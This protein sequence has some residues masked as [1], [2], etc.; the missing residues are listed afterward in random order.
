MMNDTKQYQTR[1][2]VRGLFLKRLL[3]G[4]VFALS[5][6]LSFLFW[7]DARH[8]AVHDLHD[9]FQLHA[10]EAVEQLQQRM[11]SYQQV[12]RGVRALFSSSVSVDRGEFHNY[13]TALD[14]EQHY[15]GLQA[16]GHATIIQSD[17]LSQH[18]DDMRKQGFS[19]YSISPPGNRAI[20]APVV[21]IEPMNVHNARVIGYD[22]NV[23]PIRHEAMIL[24][25]DSGT[26]AL[27]GKV[28]LLQDSEDR[29]QAGFL[30][31]MPL[32][33]NGYPHVTVAER[34]DNITGWVIAVFRMSDLIAGLDST[35]IS[36]LKLQIYDGDEISE[37]SWMYNSGGTPDDPGES[38]SDLEVI[39]KIRVAGHTWTLVLQS[40]PEFESRI[41]TDK[42]LLIAIAGVVISLLLALLVRDV[43][44]ARTMARRLRDSEERWRFAL[45]GAGDGVWDWNVVTNEVK[46][47]RRWKEMLGFSDNE[48]DNEFS[49]WDQRVH[50]QDRQSAMNDIRAHI[51]GITPA[52]VN[53]HR[54]LCKDGSWKWILGRGKII[55]RTPEGK[56]LRII[57][58]QTDITQRKLNENEL[59]QQRDFN[60]AVLDVAGNVIAVLDMSGCFVLINHAVEELTGFSKEELLGQ[61]I[62]DW[63]IPEDQ[64]A[65]VKQVV[66][67]LKAGNVEIATRYENDWLTR[68]G[69]RRTFSWH[70]T[71]LK[72][73]KGKT[74]HIVT[75]GYD[76]TSRKSDE[77]KIRRLSRL[78]ATL[79]HC[80]Q[81]IVH[82]ASRDDLFPEA[83]RDIVV[84]G[85]YMMA[86][87]G[88]IDAGNRKVNPVASYGEGIDYLDN[89][90]ITIDASE[91]SGRGPT[92]TSIRENQA[93]W[94]QDF[95]N[96][97]CTRYWHERGRRFNWGSS[98]AL[99]LNVSGV[100]VGALTLYAAEVDAFDELAREL[101]LQM[102]ADIS[103][104]LDK[105]AH[106]KQRRQAETELNELNI[107]LENRVRE[108]T[109]ALRKAVEQ[110]DSANRAKS[111]FLSNMSHEIR[112]PL[113]AIIGFS[114]SLMTDDLDPAARENAISTVVRNGKHLQQIIN[115]VLDL[116]K[117]EAGQLDINL[118]DTSV[119]QVLGE[120]DTLTGMSA[121]EKGLEF[122]I[123][124]HFPLPRH[125]LTDPTCL[126]QIL[127]N[128]CSNAIKFTEKGEVEV[129][130]SCDRTYRNIR[131]VITDT[132]IGMTPDEVDRIF[133]PFAQADTTTTRRFGGTGLGLS[134]S[135][136]LANELG[137]QLFCV[138][139]KDHGSSFTLSITNHAAEAAVPI[140]SIEEVF[141]HYDGPDE[142]VEVRQLQ[143]RILLVEDSVDN[144]QLISMYVH[145][146]GASL[147]ITQNGR[148]GVDAALANN[149]DLILMDMQM[150]VMD[151][152]AAT[153][154]LRKNG[155]TLPIVSLTANAMLSDRE[156]CINAG[157]D[158]YL[159]KPIDLNKF[160]GVL[161]RYLPH[162][163]HGNSGIRPDA[164]NPKTLFTTSPK[165]L[166]IVNRFLKQLPLF[167]REITGA[168][169]SGDWDQL[170]AKSHDLKGM[171][172]AV[173]FPEITEIAGRI[174]QMMKNRDHDHE[175]A[176]GIC[177][178]LEE[179]CTNILKRTG[180]D[181]NPEP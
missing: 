105:F 163:E 106:E 39:R 117:I 171:G 60:N 142:Q 135:T 28:T 141:T 156:K 57:G 157:A 168:A 4:L 43:L 116:S 74:T 124:Y 41:N 96:D 101:L 84:H 68:G 152:V 77:E 78:Y 153:M 173:G 120:I 147:T 127:I 123:N 129:D 56:P 51:D 159:V 104:A 134:I 59:K 13:Y 90:E 99:P 169:Q 17:R 44:N 46:F 9:E 32:Y 98:A 37:H 97:P 109:D 131:F 11:D 146:T 149:Y 36:N 151:G 71:T 23:E 6:C 111:D 15:S 42:Q 67:N 19:Q 73:D 34:R 113:A 69:G 82:S 132:G 50:P 40:T 174:N 1:R 154:E 38:D 54:L 128:L 33:R 160:Y 62:W 16:L 22:T 175:R 87:I 52:F 119:F 85:G 158:D 179:S 148:A 112:S 165:Y 48:I 5:L 177:M 172:G 121:R 162:A 108:R 53:E 95:L 63:V 45:E 10:R 110:A 143:G 94:C 102:A 30:M 155:Y 72:D 137:G 3:P 133:D 80:D 21:Y 61:P 150:P 138:S 161:N 47:S 122:S 118:I 8:S 114:E 181:V 29:T 115:D 167:V 66:E 75:L 55:S 178:E 25:R 164:G 93:V 139:Q 58:T 18:I 35:R 70:N 125:I 14:I 145:K 81:A 12:L 166:A 20:Y 180:N 92:G 49:E 144:Q 91:P 79:S 136:R 7:Q 86:W 24:A 83:C 107:S 76:I 26:A 64:Q 89:L 126:K 100:T 2:S 170:E 88:M 130:V 27:S 176:L 103:F 140:Y 31:F 65:G